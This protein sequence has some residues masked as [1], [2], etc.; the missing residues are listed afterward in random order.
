MVGKFRWIDRPTHYP[1]FTIQHGLLHTLLF[2]QFGMAFYMS[3][4]LFRT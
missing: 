2:L 4:F 3:L 1:L